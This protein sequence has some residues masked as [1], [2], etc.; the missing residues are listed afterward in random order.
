MKAKVTRSANCDLD[1]FIN[2]RHSLSMKK[3]LLIVLDGLGDRPNEIFNGRTSLQAAFRPNLNRLATIGITGLMHPVAHGIVAG[4]DTSHLSL[5][6]YDPMEVYTGRGPF[7]AMG[8]GIQVRGGDI[9]FRANFATS[10]KNGVVTDR[11]AG[12]DSTGT[13]TLAKLISMKIDDVEFIVREGVEHRAALVMRGPGLSPNVSDSDPHVSGKKSP[14]I[15]PLDKN[16]NRTAE[17]LN[18]YLAGARK[19]LESAEINGKRKER[20]IPEANELLLRGAGLVPELENFSSKYRMKGACVAGIPL[21]TGIGSLVGLDVHTYEKGTGTLSSDF[22]G[23]TRKALSLLEDYDFV[24]MNIKAP[25]VAGHDGNPVEKQKA[26]ERIDAAFGQLF[27]VLHNTVIAITGDHSTPCSTGEHSGDPLPVVF[28]T[29]GIRRDEVTL[30]DEVSCA[31][32]ALKIHSGEVMPYLLN[33]S[34]RSE[35]YGA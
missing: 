2:N 27:D 8:L 33:L 29:S 6:G 35:K 18:R 20:G 24:I 34:D 23:K 1:V 28:V 32:G 5:L 3:I 21:I 25:D 10:D 15:M 22:Y 7:E 13:E 11:R 19:I 4:S 31:S 30:Y 26:L 9:A 16:A 17:L 14:E 12:R